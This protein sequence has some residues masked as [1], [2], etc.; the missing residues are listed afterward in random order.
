MRTQH[1]V[2]AYQ[3]EHYDVSLAEQSVPSLEPNQVLVANKA[4]GINP[5]DWK[6]IQANP[7]T[8][9]E[10]HIAGVDGAGVIVDVG[11]DVDQAWIGTPVAYHA[12]LARHGSFAEHTPVYLNR[13]MKLPKTMA[14]SLAAALP[15]PILTAWQAVEKIPVKP[16]RNV[17]ISGLGAVTKLVTQLLVQRG[18]VVDVIS[19]SCSAELAEKLGIRKVY[20]QL[21][22]VD[23]HY[24]AAYDAVGPD[25]AAELVPYIKANGHVVCIQGRVE[26]PIDAPFTKTISYHEI[27]LGALHSFGDEQDWLEL[28]NDGEVLFNHVIEHKLV[29]ESPTEFHFDD[30][31]TALKHSE[32]SKQK[33][34]VVV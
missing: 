1:K 9:Q 25:N 27:A 30:M 19:K 28:M 4:I 33:S 10:G 31:R 22:D 18:F 23:Q 24:F 17:L 21:N 16:T 3:P 13:L 8:W 15:C 29:V 7:L 12:A 5:V 14:F 34:V 26:T 6:F 32:T 11:E 20:R 2:W